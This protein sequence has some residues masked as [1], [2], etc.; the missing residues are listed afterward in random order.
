MY[1]FLSLK[2]YEMPNVA[3]VYNMKNQPIPYVP[4]VQT[5]TIQWT[6]QNQGETNREKK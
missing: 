4:N 3:N 6:N 1:T 2:Q 5:K